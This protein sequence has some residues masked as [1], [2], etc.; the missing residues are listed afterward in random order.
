M[1][2]DAGGDAGQQPAGWRVLVQIHH[3][4]S[5]HVPSSTPQDYNALVGAVQIWPLGYDDPYGSG[6]KVTTIKQAMGLLR[7]HE[8]YNNPDLD[9]LSNAGFQQ[10]KAVSNALYS[11]NRPFSL[12]LPRYS[13][14]NEGLGSLVGTFLE[15]HKD[16][17]W[18]AYDS[19]GSPLP[20]N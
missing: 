4:G 18:Q 19:N 1:W 10:A 9:A 13:R 17:G 14:E 2:H 11:G 15:F 7:G 12:N 5:K 3:V 8:A 6:S 16:F 20:K